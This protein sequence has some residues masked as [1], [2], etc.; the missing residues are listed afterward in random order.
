MTIIGK[1]SVWLGT[2]IMID[3]ETPLAK[4]IQRE[5]MAGDEV[6]LTSSPAFACNTISEDSL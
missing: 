4:I 6:P 2:G 1:N 5:L 3:R